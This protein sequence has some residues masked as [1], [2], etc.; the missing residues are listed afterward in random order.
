M[1][2]KYIEFVNPGYSTLYTRDLQYAANTT[3]DTND[4]A[5]PFNPDSE[6]PL[7]EGEWLSMTDD[8]KLT[9]FGESSVSATGDNVADVPCFLHFSERGRYDAQITKKAH[10]VSGPAGFTFTSKLINGTFSV[11]DLVCV[12]DIPSPL[13]SSKFV[14]GLVPFDS[15]AFNSGDKVFIV[16][17]VTRAISATSHIEVQFMPQTIII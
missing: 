6:N 5:N 2:G 17:S 8:N 4:P 14:K 11:G 7:L 12:A 16:G 13:N 15:T 3:R 9:R 10:V 1:A